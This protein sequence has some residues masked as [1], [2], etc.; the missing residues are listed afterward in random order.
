MG[1][2]EVK[3]ELLSEAKKEADRIIKEG[4][5]EVAEV[6]SQVDQRVAGYKEKVDEEIKNAVDEMQKQGLSTAEVQVR[7]ALSVAKKDII[8]EVFEKAKESIMKKSQE[9]YLKALVKNCQKELDVATVYVR[10]EDKKTLQALGK[11]AVET[12]DII[13]GIIA[14]TSDGSIRIDCSFDSML[15]DIQQK[16]L[17]ELGVVLFG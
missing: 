16:H 3:K 15:K 1:L 13:G 12:A 8:D 4:K 6:L 7:N 14:E 17:A 9:P 5:D 11:F 2:E 10:L